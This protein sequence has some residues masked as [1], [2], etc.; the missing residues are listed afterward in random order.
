MEVGLRRWLEKREK[1][2]Q[3]RSG[4]AIKEDLVAI[5]VPTANLFSN[6]LHVRNVQ[7]SQWSRQRTRTYN[8]CN[9]TFME[10]RK[11]EMLNMWLEVDFTNQGPFFCRPLRL[12]E[13][14]ENDAEVERMPVPDEAECACV[15][16]LQ[17][18]ALQTAEF[19]KRRRDCS[20][21]RQGRTAQVLRNLCY[22][23]AT[24]SKMILLTSPTIGGSSQAKSASLRSNCFP[25]IYWRA[26]QSRYLLKARA[27]LNLIFL[28]PDVA[29]DGR[30]CC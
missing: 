10:S 20:L 9:C 19:F 1:S 18:Q 6:S 26:Q 28:P 8:R 14:D 17:C 2:R 5:P 12:S 30:C 22:S 25:S 23:I 4:I 15:Y 16:F 7:Q 21:I 3:Q 27:G 13:N 29:S 11:I 24:K